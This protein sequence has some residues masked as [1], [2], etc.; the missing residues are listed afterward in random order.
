M[1]VDRIVNYCENLTIGLGGPEIK[2]TK[3]FYIDEP[4]KDFTI[5][6]RKMIKGDKVS[7]PQW[8]PFDNICLQ[9]ND[10]TAIWFTEHITENS[11][12]IIIKDVRT[13]HSAGFSHKI[14][15]DS[16]IKNRMVNR[17]CQF[18]VS[19][20]NGFYEPYYIEMSDNLEFIA[21]DST[22]SEF[23]SGLLMTRVLILWKFLAFL[24]CKNTKIVLNKHKRKK[25]NRQKKPLLSYYTLEIKN[26]KSI[27]ESKA[28]Q[29][30][31]W[32]NR[33]HLCRGHFKTYTVE[34][35]LFGSITGR[36][37]WQP[38][39]RGQNKKGVVMKDYVVSNSL[40][41][42]PDSPAHK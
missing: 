39:V 25:L 11:D 5:S 35:P 32:S 24:S 2:N 29:K 33:I 22:H 21:Y 26:I 14:S 13:I 23:V 28:N 9:F 7:L 36:F 1:I 19:I 17:Y 31:I 12:G 4:S 34:N 3:L 16:T 10:G 41:S 37:W 6:S 18:A 8:L 40:S 15:F 27:T 30:N 38:S 42:L 20:N